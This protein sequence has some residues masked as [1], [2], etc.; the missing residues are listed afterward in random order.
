MRASR[1]MV[2]LARRG[3]QQGRF[4]VDLFEVFGDYPGFRYQIVIDTQNR[5]TPDRKFLPKFWHA[6]IFR[7]FEN[8]IRNAFGVD[9]HANA[10][11]IG[12]EIG[13]IER[14]RP[15]VFL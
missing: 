8:D 3:S 15:Q 4:A 12:A 10:R 14:H 9:L 6:S 2:A 5:N 11:R 1:R 13:R 7:Q